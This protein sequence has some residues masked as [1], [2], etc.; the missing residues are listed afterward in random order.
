MARRAHA[1]EADQEAASKDFRW[2]HLPEKVAA[3]VARRPRD[4][5]I[6]G[7]DDDIRALRPGA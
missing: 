3:G 7:V 1:D 2:R 5:G 4:V 6:G